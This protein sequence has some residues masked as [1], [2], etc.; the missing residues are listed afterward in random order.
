MGVISCRLSL[1]PRVVLIASSRSDARTGLV[2]VAL[3]PR[4]LKSGWLRNEE[5]V[6]IMMMGSPREACLLIP[7]ASLKPSDSGMSASIIA[8]LNGE[9]A[10]SETDKSR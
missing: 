6:S 1:K 8:S 7:M 5:W 3:T 9:A 10:A 2:T 4:P